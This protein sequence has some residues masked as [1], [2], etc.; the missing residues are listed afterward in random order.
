MF[1]FLYRGDMQRFIFLILTILLFVKLSLNV[2]D[3]SPLKFEE[4]LRT[5]QFDKAIT[6]GLVYSKQF[7]DE[8]NK[9]GQ[10]RLWRYRNALRQSGAEIIE[11]S[12]YDTE[13]VLSKKMARLDALLLPGGIDVHSKFYT[14]EKQFIDKFQSSDIE[15]DIFEFRLIEYARNQKL[16]LF[17]ICRGS[18]LINVALGGTLYQDLETF[19]QDLKQ[20]HLKRSTA[21]VASGDEHLLKIKEN[22]HLYEILKV[23]E[24]QTNSWHHQ[25][26]KQVAPGLQIAGISPDNVIEAFFSKNDWYVLGIQSH[27]EIVI[28]D[29][30]RSLFSNVFKDFVKQAKQYHFNYTPQFRLQSSKFLAVKKLDCLS[31]FSRRIALH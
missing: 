16:P 10:D 6:V 18:Q 7:Y 31:N 30:G 26:V 24:I 11:I 29:D 28:A 5:P 15:F 13:A 4:V 23:N 27:P 17:G 22:S 3:A 21:G 14:N 2:C 19:K 1:N 9:T 25:A 12:Q 20:T 8:F